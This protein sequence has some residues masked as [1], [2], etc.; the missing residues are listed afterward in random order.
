GDGQAADGGVHTVIAA[1]GQGVVEGECAGGLPQLTAA[2]DLVT[3]QPPCLYAQVAGTLQHDGGLLGLGGELD[4]VRD[5]G[6]QAA[7]LVGGPLPA[8]VEG[9]VDRGVPGA[10][11]VG[12]VDRD[13][14]QAEAAERTGVLVGRTDA[15]RGGFLVTGL[16]HDQHRVRVGEF[17]RCPGRDPVPGQIVID[18]SAG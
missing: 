13:L 17:T 1:D 18:R 10:A 7:L 3:G 14:A 2:V 6:E 4:V 9:P 16:I 15:V 11:R 8:E 5:V 12:E